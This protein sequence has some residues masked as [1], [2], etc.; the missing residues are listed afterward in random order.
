M[1]KT[2][3]IVIADG[4]EEIEAFT[5]GDVL[6]RCGVDVTYA[7]VGHNGGT[8]L[9]GGHGIPLRASMNV[10]DVGDILF[11]AIVIP[12][13]GGGADHIAQSKTTGT[14][15]INHWKAGKIVA[16]I[17]ASPAVVIGPLGILKGKHVTCYPGFEKRLPA[18]CIQSQGTVV[19]DG[20]LITSRGPGTAMEFAFKL[21]EKLTSH[22][23]A[24]KVAQS[25]LVHGLH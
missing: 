25:M 5:P 1:S 3:L 22:D 23:A 8:E 12:G 2:A 7:A 21:A 20:N 9:R 13:G 16:S 10:E 18:D 15:I 19:V 4:T 14:L 11:D 24:H 17:C 6:A